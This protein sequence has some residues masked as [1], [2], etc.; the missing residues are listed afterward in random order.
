MPWDIREARNE[1]RMSKYPSRSRKGS[2]TARAHVQAALSAA[3]GSAF[4]TPQLRAG[5]AGSV[6]TPAGKLL[7]MSRF[8]ARSK[9]CGAR[10]VL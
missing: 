8:Q 2:F 5:R 9:V 10:G 6:R 7:T 3:R 1:K 4:L